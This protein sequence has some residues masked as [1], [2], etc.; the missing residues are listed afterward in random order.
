[1]K[2]GIL[3]WGLLFWLTMGFLGGTMIVLAIAE[4][5]PW[6]ESIASAY[7]YANWPG[8]DSQV[9]EVLHLPLSVFS[10]YDLK[11]RRGSTPSGEPLPSGYYSSYS[12]DFECP[13]TKNDN[14]RRG[15]L[16]INI[17]GTIEDAQWAVI[18]SFSTRSSPF[19]TP[20]LEGE[21]QVGDVGFGEA[22]R[23]SSYCCTFVRAN[24]RVKLRGE[25]VMVKEL[26]QKVDNLILNAP[27]LSDETKK[28]A[29]LFSKD[30]VS[31]F[32]KS[33]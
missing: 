32:R 29:L 21:S 14:H 31:F 13:M 3:C 12:S 25:E 33:R 28:P 18:E 9:R 8:K 16:R 24:V 17:Y 22:L 10:G 27:P 30:F 20:R 15:H 7:D 23:D 26:A 5:D 1:M 19:K 11:L 4:E 6:L 2:H